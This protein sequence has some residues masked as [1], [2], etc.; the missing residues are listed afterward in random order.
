MG[1]FDSVGKLFTNV[2]NA[3]SDVVAWIVDIPEIPDFGS[4]QSGYLLNKQS[5]DAPIPII[6]GERLIGG[7][8]VFLSTGGTNNVNLYIAIVLCE[9]EVNSIGNVYIDDVISSDAKFSGLVT[10][11]RKTGLD[12]QAAST[13]L[14]EAPNWGS[15]HKLSGIAYIG[16]KIVFNKDAFRGIPKITAIVQGRKIYDP[17]NSTTDYS[18]NP[19]LCLRDY[20]TNTRYGKG[21]P[22]AEIDDAAIITAANFCDVTNSP[23][24]GGSNQKIFTCN[25]II[26]TDKTTFA[27]TQILLRGMRGLL[28]YSGGKYKLVIDDNPSSS[29]FTFNK[30]NIISDISVAGISRKD[31]YNRCVAKFANPETNWQTDEV[32]YPLKTSSEYTQFKAADNGLEQELQLVIPTM[33]SE[34]QARDV[35]RVAVLGS[36]LQTIG[37]SF[38][39]DSSSIEVEVGDKVTFDYPDLDMSDKL[40]KCRKMTINVDGTCSFDLF[41]HNA[42]VYPWDTTGEQ[43]AAVSTPTFVDP[44]SVPF[45]TLASGTPSLLEVNDAD[46]ALRKWVQFE[47]SE[48]T[49]PYVDYYDVQYK[50]G[51]DWRSSHKDTPLLQIYGYRTGISYRFRYRIVNIF[52]EASGYSTERVI[53]I[54]STGRDEFTG[55]SIK[56]AS[57]PVGKL[58]AGTSFDFLGTAQDPEYKFFLGP[59]GSGTG[60]ENSDYAMGGKAYQAGKGGVIS[61]SELGP[62]LVSISE[63]KAWDSYFFAGMFFGG[64]NYAAAKS[65]T[66]AELGSFKEA[67][68]FR[69]GNIIS[70]NVSN[71]TSA[72]PAVITTSAAHNL[73]SSDVVYLSGFTG[74]WTPLNEVATAIT[75]TSSTT[76]TAIGQDTSSLAAYSS[77]GGV[78]KS[79]RPAYVEDGVS[80]DVSL[81]AAV[82]GVGYSVYTNVGTAG[83]F[84][85]SHDG[86]MLHEQYPELGDILVDVEVIAAPTVNDAIT[87]VSISVQANQP[88]VIG[89]FSGDLG[90]G[91]I[92]ASLGEDSPFHAVNQIHTG[93]E[94]K[95]KDEYIPLLQ[96]YKFVKINSIGEGKINVCGQ[97]GGLAIGDLIV[98]SD[99]QGKGMKQNDDIIRSYTVAKSRENVTFASAD[100]VKQIAC[101]YLG[102]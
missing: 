47:A 91:F 74:A 6:Y 14:S 33:T 76:F 71:A 31:R 28:P 15:T 22:T 83:P 82:G 19:A 89:V 90:G 53:N 68:R 72:N 25:A 4:E 100:E 49:Y 11:D 69:V 98:A 9:G 66:R 70:S 102:G 78:A 50:E 80:A 94:R 95:L 45:P 3:F 63:S 88:G 67:G 12:N 38:T 37:L 24:S 56:D 99:T 81:A 1:L 52:G 79:S 54:G 85:A 5:N 96:T 64:Y 73:N 2:V 21:I 32:A 34:Y 42:S 97:G 84:T 27:N 101:I 43:I 23:Y 58:Q 86:M 51:S 87:S 10:I 60:F 18:T 35:A 93:G 59:K 77:N 30:D 92:P 39:A 20:L 75:V 17:R 46:G 48:S 61:Y 8:R 36:R 62:G 40:F 29:T 7:T 57:E 26:G 55:E 13:V 65:P 44:A 16:L 41:E